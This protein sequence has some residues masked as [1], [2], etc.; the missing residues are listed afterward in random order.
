[1]PLTPD[2]IEFLAAYLYEYMRLEC[3]PAQRKFQARGLK[4]T[5]V[6]NLLTAYE[7]EHPPRLET[8][9]DQE[10]RA[11]DE[12]IWGNRMIEPPD[13]PWA[14]AVVARQRNAEI[15]A[16]TSPDEADRLRNGHEITSRFHPEQRLLEGNETSGTEV[17][18]C[19]FLRD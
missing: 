13:P 6:M 5:D 15:R 19:P 1:M 10:G 9:L 7:R 17:I 8:H 16:E 14:N 11:V 2:E 18:S 4:Y 12:L 3:G